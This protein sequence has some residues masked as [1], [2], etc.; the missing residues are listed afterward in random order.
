MIE[1]TLSIESEDGSRV[2]VPEFLEDGAPN[3]MWDE[4]WSDIQSGSV[5]SRAVSGPETNERVVL[6]TTAEAK[7]NAQQVID[8]AAMQV[9]RDKTVIITI[10]DKI[11]PVTVEEIVLQKTADA[12]VKAAVAARMVQEKGVTAT[13]VDVKT[14]AEYYGS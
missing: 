1:K 13:A 6:D 2:N 9:I 12:Q 11:M 14:Y 5:V 4:L 10:D 3:P 7:Y 8:I